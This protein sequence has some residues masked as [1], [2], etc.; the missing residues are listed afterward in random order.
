MTDRDARQLAFGFDH[1]PAL[2]A[3]SF[4]VDDSNCDAVA[5]IDRWPAWPGRVLA[6]A[7]PRGAGKSHL[8]SVWQRR[9]GARLLPARRLDAA[10]LE[11]WPGGA[12]ALEGGDEGV[13]EDALFH[14]LNLVREDGGHLLLTARLAPAR[15]PVAL[16]DLASRLAALPL[17]TVSAPGDGLIAAVLAKQFQDRQLAVADEVIAY[18]VARMERSFTAI[19]AIV[20]ALDGLSLA[21]HRAITVPLAR[22]VLA[23]AGVDAAEG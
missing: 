18:L 11:A 3:E 15:W 10:F 2:G 5:W 21:E 13:R 9:S 14:L 22:R 4:L 8:A 12:V 19:A 20:A 16:P 23:A 1:R 17:A 6:L 7:G